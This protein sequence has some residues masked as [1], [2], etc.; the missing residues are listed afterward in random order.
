MALYGLIGFPLSH[1]KSPEYF[2][3]L[4]SKTNKK[5]QYE[6]FP[7]QSIASL[8]E[9]LHQRKEIK[10]LNVTLPYKQAVIPFCHHLD[11]TAQEC[12]SVNT[13]VVTRQNDA[14]E[15][16]GH[17]TDYFG[18]LQSSIHFLPG[19]ASA[20]VL[21]N[22]GVSQTVQHV[23]AE[24]GIPFRVVSQSIRVSGGFDYTSL[25]P[26]DVNEHRILI[27]TTSLGM[28]PNTSE[29]PDIPYEGITDRHF[30]FDL[31]YNPEKTAFLEEGEK[32]GAALKNGLEM[33]HIQAQKAWELWE[34][35]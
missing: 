2:A 6:L 10:G 29:K 31:I 20:L 35:G 3:G 30:L 27:N 9:L 1:S 32:R 11:V 7:L 14:Y 24:L 21:G 12:G 4:F 5:H 19:N 13:L 25:S 34:C 28:Y 18:F 8:P 33:F 17:N 22:G 16:T 15:I 26:K 23:L